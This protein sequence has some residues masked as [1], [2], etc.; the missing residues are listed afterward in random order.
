MATDQPTVPGPRLSSGRIV[1]LVVVSAFTATAGW[2][3][4]TGF[5]RAFATHACGPEQGCGALGTTLYLAG[6]ILLWLLCLVATATTAH[7]DAPTTEP[8]ATSDRGVLLACLALGLLGAALANGSF[9]PWLL[10]PVLPLALLTA[11]LD[12]WG[13]RRWRAFQRDSRIRAEREDRL[14][15]HG[16]TVP[17]RITDLGHTGSTYN[18]CPELRIT[19]AFTTVDGEQHTATVI[20]AFPAYDAPRR[21]DAAEVRYDPADPGNAR[22]SL[23]TGPAPDAGPAGPDAPPTPGLDLI[24]ALERLAALHRDGSLDTAEFATAKARVLSGGSASVH[25]AYPPRDAVVQRTVRP[26]TEGPH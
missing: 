16:V 17:G 1:G 15:R 7:G 13:A 11:V 25:P 23:V 8:S 19:V 2:L 3:T 26:G 21:G 24:A 14:E 18:D 10:V 6:G 20:E 4:A 12:R 22:A 9:H 5:V